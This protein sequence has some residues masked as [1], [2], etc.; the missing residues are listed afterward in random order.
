MRDADGEP[1]G[2][3]FE[4]SAWLQLRAGRESGT[5]AHH[6]DVG[7]L[8]QRML[9]YGITGVTDAGH[10]NGIEEWRGFGEAIEEG[11]WLQRVKMMVGFAHLEEMR[12][13]GLKYGDTFHGGMLAVGPAKD[14][15]DRFFGNAASAPR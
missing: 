8:S 6:G 1:S 12:Q 5:N 9:A 11:M 3:L 10:D 4:M 14:H 7:Q 13:A 15:A 2:L